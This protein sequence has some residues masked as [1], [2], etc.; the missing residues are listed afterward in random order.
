MVY[1]S[2]N[3]VPLEA[4]AAQVC[5]ALLTLLVQVEQER[6]QKLATKID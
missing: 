6:Q 1:S 2:L 4:D 3:E 5:E